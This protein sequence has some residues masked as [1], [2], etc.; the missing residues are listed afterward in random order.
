V[1]LSNVPPEIASKGQMKRLFDEDKFRLHVLNHYWDTFSKDEPILL[2]HLLSF[3]PDFID[4]E[5][6]RKVIEILERVRPREN[7]Y[8][9][10]DGID[11]QDA[12]GDCSENVNEKIN[13]EIE[14]I[15]S[16][17]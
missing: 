11:L 7:P 17:I 5:I 6:R 15:K 2:K 4:S 13:K 8:E 9:Y 3:M 14:R 16:G 10:D 1:N 12:W